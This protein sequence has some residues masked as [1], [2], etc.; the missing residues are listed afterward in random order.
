MKKLYIVLTCLSLLTA[1]AAL[2][3]TTQVAEDKDWLTPLERTLARHPNLHPDWTWMLQDQAVLLLKAAG[4][5]DVLSLERYGAFWRGKALANGAFYHVAVNRYTDVI[6]HM[7]RKSLVVAAEREKRAKSVSKTMLA[8]LNGPIAVP[9]VRAAP[10]A[11]L[12]VGR[13]VASVM[14][15]VG[16]TWMHEDQVIKILQSS[17]YAE[18]RSL[19]RDPQGVWRATAIK[20][21]IAMHVAVD[22]Y[23]NVV[24]QPVSTGGLAQAD[25]SD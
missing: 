3:Q 10:P 19:R 18:I 12:A 14:G 11:A 7:D 25:P 6:A 17:G 8:T 5:S 15:E 24:T 13:P 23:G 20:N 9:S 1:S 22:F 2:A 21:D 4:Y 16:W